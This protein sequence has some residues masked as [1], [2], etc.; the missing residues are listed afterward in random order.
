MRQ[1]FAIAAVLASL[2]PLAAL[3][4]NDNNH[5]G[6]NI[7]RGNPHASAPGPIAGAGLPALAVAGVAYLWYRRKQKKN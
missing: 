5:P 6:W 2:S 7:G 3:A 1:L 4:D